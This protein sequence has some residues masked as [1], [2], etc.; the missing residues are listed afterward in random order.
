MLTTVR[1]AMRSSYRVGNP[2]R[3]QPTNVV[4]LLLLSLVLSFMLVQSYELGHAS[5]ETNANSK[6]PLTTPVEENLKV[7]FKIGVISDDDKNAVSKDESNTWVSTYL[8]GTL[9]WEKSADKITVQW[10]KANEKKVKSKYSYGGRGMELSELVTFNGNL[11]TF[12]DRTGLVYILKD[13][14][15]YPW[16]VLADGDGKNSK[17]FKSEWATEKA[18][19]LYVGSSGKE[20]TTKEGTIENYN[21]MWVKMINKNG[22]VTSLNWQTN[23]EKIRSSMNI[24]FPGYM[25]HEAACWSDKYNKWFFLPRALSQEAYDS[26]KFETQG[27]NVIISCDDKFEKCEPTQIQGKTEDKRG[28][29]N[30]K[31]VPTSEDK[32]IVGL[33]TV[34]ADDTTETYF[35]AFDLEGKV[36]LE[37]TKIDDHKYEGVDF[38]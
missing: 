35:T 29:S 3:F 4:G 20:W 22:E 2:I 15:V 16:V 17:G 14:K 7:R 32:I 13:D 25:W 36:L 28:F 23:Y 6:Y 19:N 26:K 38:V 24:T 31:F 10:D 18:G 27:A 11:L 5:G 12:D 8:T 21:P 33:K 34:E 37:E 1:Q 30:F 9:E